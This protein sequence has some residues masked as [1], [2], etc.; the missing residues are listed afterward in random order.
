MEE[1]NKELM[2][3]TVTEVVEGAV[4]KLTFK[5][6]C[7]SYG[8]ATVFGI[9]VVTTGYFAFKG[10][11]AISKKIKKNVKGEMVES[12]NDEVVDVDK[13]DIQDMEDENSEE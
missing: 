9:G 10:V 6:T 1:M 13:E 3:N 8:I 5:E 11:K 12:E 2:E 7:L 4:D